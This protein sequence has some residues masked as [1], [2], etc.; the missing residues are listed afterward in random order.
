MI[1]LTGANKEFEDILDWFIIN[2]QKHISL[3]L[4]IADFGLKKKYPNTITVPWKKNPWFFKPRAIS[5]APS[6]SVCWLDCDIEIRDDISDVFEKTGQFDFGLTED[7]PRKD[8][9]WATGLVCVNRKDHL[10]KWIT[11]SES[12]KY[13]GD[14]EAFHVISKHHSIQMLPREY[15]WLRLVG[16]NPN[17][18]A[19]H[20]TG[21]KGKKH[22]RSN[23]TK[24]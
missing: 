22:I 23:L 4:Y 17:A 16:D 20:W 18:K 3:P 21:P 15:Q 14:Q 6:N 11:E 10:S 2:Y 24:V 8:V 19:M 5:L 13:R 12:F 9:T 7:W 1:F